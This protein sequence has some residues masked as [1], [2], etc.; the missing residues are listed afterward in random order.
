VKQLWKFLKDGGY[1]SLQEEP[2]ERKYY[3]FTQPTQ[4]DFPFQI[5]LFSRKPD[6]LE[7]DEKIRFTRIA[8]DEE[9]SSLSAIMMDDNYY[10][11][12]IRH[13]SAVDGLHRADLEALIC[14]KARAFLDL[15]DRKAQ[16]ETIDEKDIKKH[17]HDVFRLAAMLAASARFVLPGAMRSDML[18]F[19]DRTRHN[20]PDNVILRVMK[21]P[22]LEMDALYEQLCENFGI[23]NEG[24]LS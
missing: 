18:A 5:E 21:A 4:D 7:S 3:R 10:N 23:G 6:A 17:K 12:T 15:V 9:V 19:A 22:N 11:Y 14:L 2:Q 24:M 8:V 16:G 13:S 1:Q 20:L